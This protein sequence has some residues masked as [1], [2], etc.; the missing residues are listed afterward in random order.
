MCVCDNAISKQI[1]HILSH[2][3][4]SVQFIPVMLRAVVIVSIYIYYVLCF[5]VCTG[6]FSMFCT[7][8]HWMFLSLHIIIQ[9]QNLLLF[10]SEELSNQCFTSYFNRHFLTFLTYLQNSTKYRGETSIGRICWEWRTNYFYR[11]R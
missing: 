2:N 8:K 7:I 9:G 10:L 3:F 1:R 11:N 6:V 5:M 4:H